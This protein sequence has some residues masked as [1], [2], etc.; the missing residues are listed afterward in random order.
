[1]K[2]GQAQAADIDRDMNYSV[3]SGD[4]AP[5]H[6]GAK[7]PETR[8]NRRSILLR[9]LRQHPV[10]G[11]FY[12]VQKVEQIISTQ[13]LSVIA[14]ASIGTIFTFVFVGIVHGVIQHGGAT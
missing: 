4:E 1:M 3:R 12:F 13:R 9:Q 5:K 2:A 6:F 7:A 11:H 8:A 14:A 10:E